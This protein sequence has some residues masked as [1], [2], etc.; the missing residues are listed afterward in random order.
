MINEEKEIESLAPWLAIIIT[1]IG[2]GLRVFI[3]DN[4]GLWFDETFSIWLS[5]HSIVDMLQ[6]IVKIDQH[7][8]LYYLLLHYWIALKGDTPDSV[9]LLSALFGTATIPVIYLIGKRMSGVVTGLVAAMILSTSASPR[10]RAC[11]PA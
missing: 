9:R 3:I 6:W 5:N 8:P 1:L 2:G 11:T 4:K 10:K 7:P